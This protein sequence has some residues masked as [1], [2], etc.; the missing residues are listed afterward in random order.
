MEQKDKLSMKIGYSARRLLRHMTLKTNF[1]VYRPSQI[2]ATAL[3]VAIDLNCDDDLLSLPLSG[4]ST[5]SSASVSPDTA[6]EN[7]S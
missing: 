7:A 5:L 2:A 6:K 4:N 1:L 3:L